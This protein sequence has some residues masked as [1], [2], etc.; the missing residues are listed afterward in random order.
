[1]NDEIIRLNKT[2]Y[3]EELRKTNEAE[4]LTWGTA[5]YYLDKHTIKDDDIAIIMGCQC[6]GCLSGL[7]H[8]EEPTLP[9][10]PEKLIR[11][12]GL[13]YFEKEAMNQNIVE[14][15][16]KIDEIISYLKEKEK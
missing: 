3:I 7:G 5:A 16:K 10:L 11:P 12:G 2:K 6:K 9:P 8:E 4:D 13:V 15:M 14:V 1:M